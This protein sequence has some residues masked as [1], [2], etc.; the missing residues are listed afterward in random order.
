M[1]KYEY[2]VKVNREIVN[3]GKT[4]SKDAAMNA[5]KGFGRGAYGSIKETLSNGDITEVGYKK[6]NK[7]LTIW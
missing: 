6:I 5:F 2:T 1:L 4:T 3:Q 7:S